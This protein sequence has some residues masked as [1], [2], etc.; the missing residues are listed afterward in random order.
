MWK[1]WS[2][3]FNGT[4]REALRENEESIRAEKARSVPHGD[5]RTVL[6]SIHGFVSFGT[7]SAECAMRRRQH[8]I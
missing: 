8:Q 1:S 7:N 3:Y 4:A 2:K 5:T 6:A